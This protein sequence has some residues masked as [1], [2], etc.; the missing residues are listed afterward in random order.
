M[1]RL[2]WWA[3]GGLAVVALFLFA[4]FLVIASN[5]LG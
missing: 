1:P 2:P 5:I 3:Y 4:S